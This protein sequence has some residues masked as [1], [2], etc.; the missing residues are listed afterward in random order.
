MRRRARSFVGRPTWGRVNLDGD[1]RDK[2]TG[3]RNHLVDAVAVIC[4][5]VVC[6][7][8]GSGPSV[9]PIASCLI[10]SARLPTFSR[11]TRPHRRVCA[12]GSANGCFDSDRLPRSRSVCAYSGEIVACPR[13]HRAVYM[14]AC[15]SRRLD[16]SGRPLAARSAAAQD[17]PAPAPGIESFVYTALSSPR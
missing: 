4:A 16:I 10:S 6:D 12:D 11:P 15:M 13:R 9:V 8:V 3:G 7:A 17:T 1:D 2:L 14:A 5:V